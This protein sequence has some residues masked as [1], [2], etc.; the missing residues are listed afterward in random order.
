MKSSFSKNVLRSVAALSCCVGST[1]GIGANALVSADS[2]RTIF[3][4]RGRLPADVYSRIMQL[5]EASILSR[6][7]NLKD[8]VIDNVPEKFKEYNIETLGNLF[9]YVNCTAELIDEE[10]SEKDFAVCTR[11]LRRLFPN[12][13]IFNG[14]KKKIKNFDSF[15]YALVKTMSDYTWA[16]YE[17]EKLLK[18]SEE[19]AWKR[20]KGTG[21]AYGYFGR[22]GYDE[23]DKLTRKLILIKLKKE[24]IW[25]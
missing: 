22:W 20:Q 24:G 3:K 2:A 11:V 18:D 12:D 25:E 23:V 6:N 21:L 9:S 17:E 15:I 16:Y 13:I 1:L 10:I 7:K 4:V 14:A 19:Q 5:S 8:E